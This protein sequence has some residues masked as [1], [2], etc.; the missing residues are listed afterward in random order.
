MNHKQILDKLSA[1]YLVNSLNEELSRLVFKAMA[2]HKNGYVDDP[3]EHVYSE[4][5]QRWQCFYGKHEGDNNTINIFHVA[6]ATLFHKY[7]LCKKELVDLAVR[8][9]KELN[10]RAVLSDAF[11]RQEARIIELLQSKPKP[12]SRYPN[13]IEST[14]YYRAGDVVA[15][16]FKDKFI[17]AYILGDTAINEAPVIEFYQG[18]FDDVPTMQ[19]LE[20]LKACGML[21]RYGQDVETLR[22][23]CH[24]VYGMKYLPD[25]S[26]QIT[27]IASAIDKG[28][29]YENLRAGLGLWT[30]SD[31]SSLQYELASIYNVPSNV[32]Q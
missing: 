14:T 4:L 30:Q 31:L 16:K 6:L 15:F 13:L 22:R 8:A 3:V 28:P 2:S 9:V 7:G 27:L 19:D 25:L 1:K 32:D 20:G 26:G 5:I 23:N 12:L 11:C 29:C 17:A 18:V 10:Q 24:A 21:H